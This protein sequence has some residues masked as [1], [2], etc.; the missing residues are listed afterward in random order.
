MGEAIR[1]DEGNFIVEFD[2]WEGR[3]TL[4][5]RNKVKLECGQKHV[6]NGII[7]GSHWEMGEHFEKGYVLHQI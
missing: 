2:E 1:S 5:L 6:E 4:K 3:S 7:R